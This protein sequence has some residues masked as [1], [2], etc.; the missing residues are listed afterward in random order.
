[1]ERITLS[2][3]SIVTVSATVLSGIYSVPPGAL[4]TDGSVERVFDLAAG[5]SAELWRIRLNP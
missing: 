2:G 4:Q 1:L 5:E 3:N